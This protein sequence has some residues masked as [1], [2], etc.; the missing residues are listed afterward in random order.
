MFSYAHRGGLVKM[1]EL[2]F[3]FEVLDAATFRQQLVEFVPLVTSVTDGQKERKT[4]E[5]HKKR[6]SPG[7]V[8]LSGVNIAFSHKGFVK[9]RRFS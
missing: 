4:I 6:R 1:K 8:K 9:V 7:L 5:D 3:F 2:F